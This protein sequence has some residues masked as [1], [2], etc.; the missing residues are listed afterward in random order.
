M[1]DLFLRQNLNK[2]KSQ[3]ALMFVQIHFQQWRYSQLCKHGDTD[4]SVFGAIS[5]TID[6]KQTQ[7]YKTR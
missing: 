3:R 2:S 4:T 1:I 5:L 7:S 6:E